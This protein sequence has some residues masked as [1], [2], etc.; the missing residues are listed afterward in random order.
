MYEH[1]QIRAEFDQFQ[2]FKNEKIKTDL[3]TDTARE[4][5]T[6]VGEKYDSTNAAN[7]Q[8]INDETK[9]QKEMGKTLREKRR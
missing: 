1:T 3:H 9:E 6:G 7:S 2:S 8:I 5:D 4:R